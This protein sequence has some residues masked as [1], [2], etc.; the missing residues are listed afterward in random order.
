MHFLVAPLPERL[1]GGN[2]ASGCPCPSLFLIIFIML[3]FPYIP[4]CVSRSLI[5]TLSSPSLFVSAAFFAQSIAVVQAS[6]RGT[7][8]NFPSTFLPLFLPFISP[9]LSSS[10]LSLLVSSFIS[11]IHPHPFINP[12]T[13]IYP[14]IPDSHMPLS[15]LILMAALVRS[16]TGKSPP[17]RHH[18]HK[19]HRGPKQA[20]KTA[21]ACCVSCLEKSHTNSVRKKKP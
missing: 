21:L 9:R 3:T 19:A 4:S 7:R 5:P 18:I 13:L 10:S 12:P 8:Q 20:E 17:H 1:R 2:T 6:H 14:C 15:L 11:H 16:E